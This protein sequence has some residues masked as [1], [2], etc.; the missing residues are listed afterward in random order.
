MLKKILFPKNGAFQFQ[1]IPGLIIPE[2]WGIIPKHPLVIL[3]GVNSDLD[4]DF[5]ITR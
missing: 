5:G 1:I 3:G 4:F 2:L